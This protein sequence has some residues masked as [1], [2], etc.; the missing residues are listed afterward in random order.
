MLVTQAPVL[1]SKFR[2]LTTEWVSPLDFKQ[3]VKTSYVRHLYLPSKGP[4]LPCYPVYLWRW[5]KES[6]GLP[7]PN[8]VSLL[9]IPLSF[10]LNNHHAIFFPILK[11]SYLII[12]LN[13]SR[14]LVQHY[15]LQIYAIL[16]LCFTYGYY[17]ILTWFPVLYNISLWLILYKIVCTS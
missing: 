3:T 11:I 12:T 1:T 10:T 4:F 15:I 14:V 2:Y 5:Y 7:S 6:C 17:K 8:S 13:L 16:R 9:H